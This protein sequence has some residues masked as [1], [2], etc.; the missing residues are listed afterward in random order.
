MVIQHILFDRSGLN[1]TKQDPGRP[2]IVGCHAEID[3]L[4]NRGIA[5]QLIGNPE[6]DFHRGLG[7]ALISIGVICVPPAVLVLVVLVVLGNPP[8]CSALSAAERQMVRIL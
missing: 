4:A 8:A 2:Q 1:R 5:Q 6:G 3:D 7:G